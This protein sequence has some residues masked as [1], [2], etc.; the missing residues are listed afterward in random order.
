MQEPVQVG[1]D[2]TRPARR[3]AEELDRLAAR[4]AVTDHFAVA[5]RMDAQLAYEAQL[6]QSQSDRFRGVPADRI[7]QRL[8]READR[9]AGMPADRLDEQHERKAAGAPVYY[10]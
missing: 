3:L 10:F 9:P 4:N 5:D 2:R 8:A 1:L 6:A 7:E